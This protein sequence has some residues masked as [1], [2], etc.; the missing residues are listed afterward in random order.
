M[1]TK[2]GPLFFEPEGIDFS[3]YLASHDWRIWPWETCRSSAT[4]AGLDHS[5]FGNL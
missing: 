1:N 5:S 3:P 4:V 2:I